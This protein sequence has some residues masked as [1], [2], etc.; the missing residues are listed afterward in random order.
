MFSSQA[1]FDRPTASEN[2][3]LAFP[4]RSKLSRRRTSLIP[5]SSNNS[6]ADV[7]LSSAF[8]NPSINLPNAPTASFSKACLNCSPVIPAIAE[9]PSR[10]L[11]ALTILFNSVVVIPIDEAIA[12]N[13]SPSRLAINSNSRRVIP[14]ASSSFLTWSKPVFDATCIL[15]SVLEIA[16]PPISASIPTDDSAA[17]SPRISASL[18]PTCEPAP[19]NLNAIAVIS[20]SVVAKLLPKST[21]DDPNLSNSVWGIPVIF[22]SFAK[23][24]AATS[25]DRFVDSPISIIVFVNPTTF[26]VLIPNCPAASAVAAISP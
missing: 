26:S 1:T 25:A 8:P 4:A 20:A 17:E 3:S 6:I 18:I 19:A 23:D 16:E 2:R 5:I 24:V 10:F 15:T 13:P 11:P 12:L 9:N 22:A 21:I 14:V 7:P